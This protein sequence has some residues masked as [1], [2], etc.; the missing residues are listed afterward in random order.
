VVILTDSPEQIRDRLLSRDGRAQSC[1]EI[2]R[3][4]TWEI[5]HGNAVAE[6]MKIPIRLFNKSEVEAAVSYILSEIQPKE[7][8]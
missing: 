2:R 7:L 1:E 4:Q 3:L 8:P 5:A 6:A